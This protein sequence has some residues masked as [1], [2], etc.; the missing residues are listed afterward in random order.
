[1]AILYAIGV[2]STV[3]HFANGL[4]TLGITWGLWTS[5][6]AMRRANAVS[7]VVGVVLAAAGLGALGGMRSIDIE[8]ARATEKRMEE[9]KRLLEGQDPSAAPAA[10][11]PISETG[12]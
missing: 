1:V 4:W 12:N 9:V 11:H 3:F 8:Q 7:V 6:A 5:P 2:L 10:T